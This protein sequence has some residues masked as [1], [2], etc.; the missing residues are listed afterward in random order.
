MQDHWNIV[1]AFVLRPKSPLNELWDQGYRR[2]ALVIY[3]SKNEIDAANRDPFDH[4]LDRIKDKMAR[5][6]KRQDGRSKHV[7][8]VLQLVS[9]KTVAKTLTTLC[10]CAAASKD[11]VLW[12]RAVRSC[13][14]AQH[15]DRLGIKGFNE[16]IDLFGF[17][18]LQPL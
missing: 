8:T 1:S 3:P 2:T 5:G 10:Q 7:D 4:S 18:P 9:L 14:V 17:E 11:L 13:G 6:W 15:I 12:M 16:G